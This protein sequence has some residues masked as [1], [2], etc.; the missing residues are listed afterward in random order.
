M[1]R[2]LHI[3]AGDGVEVR[4]EELAV[5]AARG[6]MT[7]WLWGVSQSTCVI[8]AGRTQGQKYPWVT[9]SQFGKQIKPQGTARSPVAR[10]G[11]SKA[12]PAPDKQRRAPHQ[13]AF[14]SA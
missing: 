4:R 14:A 10:G 11:A 5:R 2:S 6:E 12:A 7:W 8:N 9:Q 3:S 13:A 1:A